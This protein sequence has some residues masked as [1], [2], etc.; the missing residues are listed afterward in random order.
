MCKVD[1]VR[2]NEMLML[3]TRSRVEICLRT[4]RK[5][6]SSVG[7]RDAQ[8]LDVTVITAPTTNAEG[9]MSNFKT[10]LDRLPTACDAF[11]LS[12]QW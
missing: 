2:I 11:T 6:G 1:K 10:P 7:S 4:S 8:K 12:V 5:C 3:T 9:M